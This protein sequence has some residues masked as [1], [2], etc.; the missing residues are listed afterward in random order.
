MEVVYSPMYLECDICNVVIMLVMPS[1][2]KRQIASVSALTNH[3]Y[4]GGNASSLEV[5]P[6]SIMTEGMVDRWGFERMLSS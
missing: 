1:S 6:R 4:S 5:K 3:E 2:R